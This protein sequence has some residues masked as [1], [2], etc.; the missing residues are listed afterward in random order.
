MRMRQYRIRFR[1]HGCQDLHRSPQAPTVA[2]YYISV[3]L[4]YASIAKENIFGFTME[5]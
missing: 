4:L 5:K 3:A 2:E 1:P